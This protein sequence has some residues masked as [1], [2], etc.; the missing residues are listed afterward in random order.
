MIAA[1]I[2]EAFLKC[3]TKSYLRS[4]G[5]VGTENVYAT[6]VRAQNE[7]Y[8]NDGIKRLTEGAAPEESIT[9]SPSAI[10]LKAGNWLLAT[11]LVAHTQSLESRLQALERI[12]PERRGKPA[13]FIPIRFI[14][15]NKLTLDDK[16]LLAFDALVLSEIV[17]REIGH[18]KIIHGRDKI[19][20]VNTA[21][22][23]NKA[24]KVIGKIALLL[25][26]Q[27]PPDLILN[28]H[29]AECEFRARCRKAVEKDDLSLL[30]GMT[31]KERKHFNGKGIFSVT[32]LSYTF[33]PRRRPRY[34]AGKREKYHHSL[35]ALAIREGKIHVVG[36]P[37][38]R[39]EGTPVYLDVEGIPD[40]DFYYLIGIR[41]WKDRR[42]IQHSLWAADEYD[43]RRIWREFLEVVANKLLQLQQLSEDPDQSPEVVFTASLKW[44]HPFGFKRNTFVLPNLDT[45]NKA[46]Y[47]DYPPSMPLKLLPLFAG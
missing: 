38:L 21:A 6:W 15:N 12:V 24:R 42:V 13:Q 7:T 9:G 2:V 46:A 39:I 20:W 28:R 19:T 40:R 11:D 27:S 45:I 16:L 41:F 1:S 34:L 3:P 5:E 29:C 22:L 30:S 10:I 47:W 44:K 25:S 26:R 43:A 35:K 37:E 32:Q 14:F 31:D 36:S 18:G 33:R 23:A 8:H 4:L 17:G